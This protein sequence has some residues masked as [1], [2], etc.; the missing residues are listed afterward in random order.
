MRSEPRSPALPQTGEASV[1]SATPAGL[2]LLQPCAAL[3]VIIVSYGRPDDVRRCLA[4]LAHSRW[5]DLA[6]FICENAGPAAFEQLRAALVGENGVFQAGEAGPVG[7]DRPGGRLTQ[8]ASY[9]LRGTAIPVR[10]GQAADNLGYGGGVNAWLE[11]LLGEPG[12]EAVLVLNPDTK[13][14]ETCLGELMAKAA[15]GYGM[16]GATLV[17]DNAPDRL[18]SYGLV[19]SRISGRV[20]AAGRNEP[21][22]SEPSAKL[23]A[24][25]DTISGACILVTRA[26]VEDVGLM[27]EDYFLYMEDV[28]W[29]MRR[30]RHRIGFAVRAIV[31]HVGG[32][33]IGSAVDPRR[34]SPLSIYL[35]A[36]NAMLFSRRRSGLW[37]VTHLLTEL[38]YALRYLLIGAPAAARIL[39][40]GTIDGI[41]GKTG[42]PAQF[43][44]LGNA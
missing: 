16:V 31:R 37:S 18:V 30:G 44:R 6:I 41:R 3:C 12:W 38:F 4:S 13:V 21:A 17:F 2:D 23:L 26:F 29:G 39:L 28:D 35:S 19:W 24:R 22:G 33:A 42:R 36:R 43:D 10:I 1:A 15:E 9:Q 11:R 14:A 27:A 34:R 25:L 5:S 20:I 7:L 40:A 8:V 32:T